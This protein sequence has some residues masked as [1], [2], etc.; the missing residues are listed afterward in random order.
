MFCIE[1]VASLLFQSII[2]TLAIIAE[3][4]NIV[5]VVLSLSKVFVVLWL[6]KLFVVLW[7]VKYLL[8]CGQ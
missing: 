5:F 8:F 6:S 3:T 4:W 1:G 7:S 2:T